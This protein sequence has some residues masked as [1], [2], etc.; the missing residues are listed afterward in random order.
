MSG[1]SSWY[2]VRFHVSCFTIIAMSRHQMLGIARAVKYM[3]S[4]DIVHG[5]LKIVCP[6]STALE[7]THLRLSRQI[8]SLTLVDVPVLLASARLPFCPPRHG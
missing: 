6:S 3:H 8:S 4:L 5:N 2:V 7:I 1:E